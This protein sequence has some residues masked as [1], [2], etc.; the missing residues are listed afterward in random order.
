MNIFNKKF[1]E[2]YLIYRFV[3][4]DRYN[5]M[6]IHFINKEI[7]QDCKFFFILNIFDILSTLIFLSLGL[8]EANPFMLYIF[9]HFGLLTAIIIKM[10][11]VSVF[12]YVLMK[13]KDLISSLNTLI[14]M[15]GIMVFVIFGNLIF[16][17]IHIINNI[18]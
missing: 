4:K 2:I 14:I 13:S 3:F 8:Q 17:L 16:T 10:I 11:F 7:K 9:N 5:F 15:N 6:P 12:I 1:K 18:F